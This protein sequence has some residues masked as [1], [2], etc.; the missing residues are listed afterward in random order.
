MNHPIITQR[1]AQVRYDDMLQEAEQ[2]RRTKQ[3]TRRL[4]I[5]NLITT[6]IH[7]FI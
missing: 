3:A 7:M 6:F 1:N 5:T 2:Y 4:T